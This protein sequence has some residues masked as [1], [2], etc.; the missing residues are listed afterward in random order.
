MNGYLPVCR[1]DQLTPERGAAVLVGGEQVA[2]FRVRVGGTDVVYAVGH[3][4]PFSK[5]NV[6][7]RGIV[8][9]TGDRDVVASPMYK[10]VFDLETGECVSEPGHRLP[11]WRTRV[12]NGSV[13]VHPIP[14]DD[15]LDEVAV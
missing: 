13:L 4:D 3:H 11:V 5:A 15:S 6:M 12:D 9:S 8:G 14:V 7:A 2:L 10:Q 1:L